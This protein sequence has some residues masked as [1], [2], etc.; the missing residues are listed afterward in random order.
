MT[1]SVLAIGLGWSIASLYGQPR[2]VTYWNLGGIIQ[3]LV[4]E[5]DVRTL[6]VLGHTADWHIDKVC[7]IN[8]LRNAEAQH[9]RLEIFDLSAGS[10]DDVEHELDRVDALAMLDAARFRTSGFGELQG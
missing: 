8:E 3:K 2:R 9:G 4:T 6:G 5:H 7:L 1:A 10:P